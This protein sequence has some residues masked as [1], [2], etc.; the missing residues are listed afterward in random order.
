MADEAAIW[1]VLGFA[2]KLAASDDVLVA[3]DAAVASVLSV[4]EPGVLDNGRRGWVQK[5]EL[6]DPE[7]DVAASNLKRGRRDDRNGGRVVAGLPWLLQRGRQLVRV[8]FAHKLA[9]R[10]RSCER[11][12]M[13]ILHRIARDGMVYQSQSGLGVHIAIA[14]GAGMGK[15]HLAAWLA[16]DLRLHSLA[17]DGVVWIECGRGARANNIAGQLLAEL[18]RLDGMNTGTLSIQAAGSGISSGADTSAAPETLHELSQVLHSRRCA[19]VLDDVWSGDL[20]TPL[21]SVLSA[22]P[23][24]ILTTRNYATANTCAGGPNDAILRVPHLDEAEA[25]ELLCSR[26][27]PADAQ[28]M[29]V[30]ESVARLP[31]TCELLEL[32]H[33]TPLLLI[34]AGNLIAEYASAVMALPTANVPSIDAHCTAS[35]AAAAVAA[36]GAAVT[37]VTS[38]VV[39]VLELLR[40]QGFGG[41]TI[42]SDERYGFRTVDASIEATLSQ[43]SSDARRR[44]EQLAVAEG[45]VV[46][47]ATLRR[48]WGVPLALGARELCEWG[49]LRI[50]GMPKGGS[51]KVVTGLRSQMAGQRSLHAVGQSVAAIQVA[52]LLRSY[53]LMHVADADMERYRADMAV[54][55]LQ[56]PHHKSEV[57]DTTLTSLGRRASERWWL[58]PLASLSMRQRPTSRVATTGSLLIALLLALLL[59]LTCCPPPILFV[60][61][62]RVVVP[63][64]EDG[65]S[66]AWPPVARDASPPPPLPGGDM[67]PVGGSEGD[68]WLEGDVRPEGNVPFE[69]D[70][71]PEGG[72]LS[73]YSYAEDVEGVLDKASSDEPLVLEGAVMGS[74]QEWPSTK[75]S[76]QPTLG[77]GEFYPNITWQLHLDGAASW[78]H[79]LGRTRR[80]LTA[81]T[82]PRFELA[83]MPL[84]HMM[85]ARDTLASA[86]SS[87]LASLDELSVQEGFQVVLGSVHGVY[88]PVDAAGRSIAKF[89]A[90]WQPSQLETM[91]L[92]AAVAALS[93]DLLVRNGVRCLSL[94]QRRER[95]L[96]A[97][98]ALT[99]AALTSACAVTL[100]TTWLLGTEAWRASERVTTYDFE[101]NASTRYFVA[102]LSG[103]AAPPFA[104]CGLWRGGEVVAF[105]MAVILWLLVFAPFIAVGAIITKRALSYWHSTGRSRPASRP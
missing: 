21:L 7:T 46:H 18:G 13:R 59:V 61:V 62:A 36:E 80:Q 32:C 66:S 97:V 9:V 30:R 101:G 84:P 31:I 47:A 65:N 27:L 82:F 86:I 78:L 88:L 37:D 5:Y 69:G 24:V 3:F 73:N 6:G 103:C 100:S 4:T 68:V 64:V 17:P 45:N 77:S 91:A 48:L 34:A 35:A 52:P 81:S 8:P 50:G 76:T 44:C 89:H 38:A 75:P 1:F 67:R 22:S 40:S 94:T 57:V 33:G 105:V 43:L 42:R 26:M 96:I 10:R 60:R 11:R 98:M 54:F 71:R 92:A 29:E 28:W 104:G 19:I 102:D 14:G 39:A 25:T 12:L 53:L 51:S 74:P 90:M 79:A 63:V 16:R 2:R 41:L 87:Q 49:L 85:E 15:S 93:T 58:H 95:G 23:V 72:G 20:L 56:L 55:E 83:W 99:V 70:A